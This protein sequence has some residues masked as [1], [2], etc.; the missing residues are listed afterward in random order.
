MRSCAFRYSPSLHAFLRALLVHAA[1]VSMIASSLAPLPTSAKEYEWGCI[2]V[3]VTDDVEETRCGYGYWRTLCGWNAGVEEC[4]TF[5]ELVEGEPYEP[6]IPVSSVLFLP[7]IKGSRLYRP[8]PECEGSAA[9]AIETMS[10]QESDSQECAVK[11][12]EPYGSAAARQ[13]FLDADGRS[14]YGDVYAR[15]GDTLATVLGQD[16]YASFFDD[17]DTAGESGA[18]GPDWR[19]EAGAYDWRLSLPDIVTRGDRESDR[20]YY[21]RSASL[22]YLETQLRDLAADSPTGKV[23]IITHSNGGL[24]AKALLA[25]LGDAE[26]A[27]LVE[28]VV[29]VGVPHLG[30]PQALG[31]LL[32]GHGEAL[33][34]DRCA[35]WRVARWLCAVLM[36][37]PTARSF[38]LNAPMAYHLLPSARYIDNGSPESRP[39]LV[40]FDAITSYARER[41]A[42]G[43]TIDSEEE[44]HAFAAAREGGRTMPA[45]DDTANPSVLSEPLLAYAKDVHDS[46]DGWEVPAGIETYSVVGTNA[47]TI[48]GIDFYEEPDFLGIFGEPVPRYRPT[49]MFDGDGVVPVASARGGGAARDYLIDFEEASDESSGDGYGHGTL[50]EIPEVRSILADIIER[51]V[52]PPDAIPVSVAVSDGHMNEAFDSDTAVEEPSGQH[53]LRFFLHSAAARLELHADGRRVGM[54]EDGSL[55]DEIDGASYGEFGEVTYLTVPGGRS[56]TLVLHGMGEGYASLDIEELRDGESVI[57]TIAQVPISANVVARMEI[58]ADGTTGGLTLVFDRDGNGTIDESATVAYGTTTP[59]VLTDASTEDGMAPGSPSETRSGSPESSARIREDDGDLVLASV[60]A[61]ESGPATT[62]DQASPSATVP[63]ASTVPKSPPLNSNTSEAI[64]RESE[65]APPIAGTANL[66][67]EHE[68]PEAGPVQGNPWPLRTLLI[69]GALIALAGSI[70]FMV[71]IRVSTSRRHHT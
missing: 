2:E 23:T 44:L 29:F 67:L 5:F 53:Q 63:P 26:A 54:N 14:I 36:D 39:P 48:A 47:E 10:L 65:A 37:R 45:E 38:G 60:P 66:G 59:Y 31:A 51:T 56:Y 30:A 13:L 49:F 25:K 3:F 20:I 9:P 58:P 22:P 12:W 55:D 32:F 42:Y 62:T 61:L 17:L 24:V 18:Y 35:E 57:S 68:N 70:A 15:A 28:K 50:F 19:W 71:K 21:T 33:P 52:I 34:F 69:I 8:S 11:L 64:A 40:R 27:T 6:E 43:T 1:L 41:E 4:V 16:F 46:L 7:G